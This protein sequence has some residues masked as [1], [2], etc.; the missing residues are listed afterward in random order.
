MR[1][2][3][4]AAPSWFACSRRRSRDS[5]VTGSVSGTSPVCCTSISLAQVLEQIAHDPREVLAALG[6]ILEKLERSGAVR[7]DD[8]VAEAEEHLVLD[9][10]EDVEHLPDGDLPPGR[11]RELVE[12]RFGVAEGPVAAAGDERERGIGSLDRLGVGDQAELAHE[13]GQPRAL[14]DERLAARTDGGEHLVEL[15]RAEDEEEVGR[16]LLDQLEE[17]VPCGIR[18]Q[19]LAGPSSMM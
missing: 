11:G 17:R 7:V 14:E 4:V 13:F 6:E 12:R 19:E 15:G 1:R 5:S 8:E 9:R 10:A 16:R 18:I 2:M 3:T